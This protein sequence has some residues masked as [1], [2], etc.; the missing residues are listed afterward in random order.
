M[1]NKDVKNK[2]EEFND[3]KEY[4]IIKDDLSYKTTIKYNKDNLTIICDSFSIILN[5]I[6]LIK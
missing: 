4:Y 2:T 6:D 5:F 1:S 3:I